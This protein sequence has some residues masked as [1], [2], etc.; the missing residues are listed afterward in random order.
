MPARDHASLADEVSSE[1]D[2]TRRAPKR[3]EARS[4]SA[5]VSAEQT[6]RSRGGSALPSAIQEVHKA[7]DD[8]A[9]EFPFA[10]APFE[11]VK[12]KLACVIEASRKDEARH[13][14]SH[15]D[16]RSKLNTLFPRLEHWIKQSDDEDLKTFFRKTW[17]D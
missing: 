1:G 6:G 15:R 3:R 5:K 16:V 13:R 14:Q 9:E 7:I 2:V 10:R 12:T 11:R 8:L 17:R 4:I